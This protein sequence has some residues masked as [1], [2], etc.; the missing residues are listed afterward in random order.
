MIGKAERGGRL[1]IDAPIYQSASS[2]INSPKQSK[3]E[4]ENTGSLGE[5]KFIVE[6]KAF[7]EEI[8]M[9]KF[10]II[11]EFLVF[12]RFQFYF[13]VLRPNANEKR[14]HFFVFIESI[15]E[16]EIVFEADAGGGRWEEGL[17]WGERRNE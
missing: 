2:V 16:V 11:F 6:R 3:R 13:I 14:Q 5:L 15:E 8:I 17:S 9:N 1:T 7:K 12:V 4:K 10:Y